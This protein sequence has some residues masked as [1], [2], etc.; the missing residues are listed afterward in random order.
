MKYLPIF[1]GLVCCILLWSISMVKALTFSNVFGLLAFSVAIGAMVFFSIFS[2]YGYVH[3]QLS[4]AVSKS[5]DFQ[6]LKYRKKWLFLLYLQF[7]FFL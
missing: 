4:S 2:P 7:A 5:I 3:L 6:S 1:W